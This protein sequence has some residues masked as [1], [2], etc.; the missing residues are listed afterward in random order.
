[1]TRKLT[2]SIVALLVVGLLAFDL[3]ASEPL[4]PYAQPAFLALGSG[5]VAA[6]AHCASLPTAN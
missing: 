1:M 4:D 2:A 3:A 6:G 5:A